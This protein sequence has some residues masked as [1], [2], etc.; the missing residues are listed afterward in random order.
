MNGCD[1]DSARLKM[2]ADR[3]AGTEKSAVQ[4]SMC[5]DV[6]ASVTLQS[7]QYYRADLE[8]EKAYVIPP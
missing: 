1:L 3:A 6:A 5:R 8:R 2:R 4:V 7:C